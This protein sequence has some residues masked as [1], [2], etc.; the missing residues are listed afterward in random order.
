MLPYFVWNGI[1]SRDA[2]IRV[3]SYPPIMRPPE[4]VK[5]VTIPGRSGALT[6]LE[7]DDIYD[8]YT[9]TMIVANQPGTEIGWATKFLRGAGWLILGND[10]DFAY[11]TR[12]QAQLQM[13]KLYKGVWQGSVTLYTQ[14]L[15]RLAIPEK[16][17]ALTT[18]GTEIINP[19]A[20]ASRPRILVTTTGD[21][22]FGI[23]DE[24]MA[25]TGC[26][27]AFYY[28]CDTGLFTDTNGNIIT[29]FTV[30]GDLTKIPV[31]KS[32][33]YWSG[34]TSITITPRWRFV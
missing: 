8:P 17:I 12:M 24:S 28:D 5:N 26:T 25:V 19:G 30:A 15:K 23:G 21:C 31:G 11:E 13:D 10:P 9:R 14:P 34:A 27:S 18:T 16:D 2:G 20:V 33:V 29:T 6:L 3:V 4:R 1:D 22:S 32:E 7:G